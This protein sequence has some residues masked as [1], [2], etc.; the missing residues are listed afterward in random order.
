[1]SDNVKLP[2]LTDSE[3]S[4]SNRVATLT[5]RRHDVRNALTGTALI[6]DI[7]CVAEWVNRTP[8]ISVLVLTGE[9]SAF[10][11][12]GNIKEMSERDGIHKHGAFGGDVYTVQEKY[13]LGIQRIPLAMNAIDIPVIAAINGP[14]IGAGF[15]L[16]CMCDLR[17]GSTKALLGETFVNLGIIPGDGGAWFLQRLIGYQKAAELT[18]TG[19]MISADEAKTLGI[20][21]EVVEHEQLMD[22]AMELAQRMA[23]KPPQALRM[24]KRLLK[25]A[26]K[27]EL[28]E[29]L[30]QC[31]LMQGICHNTEDHLEAVNAFVEKRT[32]SYQGR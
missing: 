29:F 16:T 17:I 32:P 3:L 19:R 31:A 15:D 23:D 6:E 27:M 5:F 4:L 12:G 30:E 7:I 13:R 22:R 21:L 10:S 20:L 1:M 24:T 2:A 8:E 26:Q 18:L 14:A 9:G 28:P 25:S 11:A